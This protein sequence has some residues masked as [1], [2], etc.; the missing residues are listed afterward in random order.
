MREQWLKWFVIALSGTAVVAA[1]LFAIVRSGPGDAPSELP[2]SSPSVSGDPGSLTD[3]GRVDASRDEGPEA[4]SEKTAAI[5]TRRC[6]HCHTQDEVVG[7]I[8]R[9]PA[10]RRDN[11]TSDLLSRHHP[12]TDSEHEALVDYLVRLSRTTK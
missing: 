3:A 6:G 10:S 4:Q 2:P 9:Q 1:T 7:A 11:W 12:P 8:A 5:F